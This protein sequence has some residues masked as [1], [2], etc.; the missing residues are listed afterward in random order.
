MK[1]DHKIDSICNFMVNFPV[2]S[3]STAFLSSPIEV[4]SKERDARHVLMNW[5]FC[6][7]PLRIHVPCYVM[8]P[9]G[10][11]VPGLGDEKCIK[12]RVTARGEL[13]SEDVSAYQAGSVQQKN[14]IENVRSARFFKFGT[15]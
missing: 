11:S 10:L 13:G 6:G 8:V 7:L 2:T 12:D 3:S 14:V 9:S 15:N 5:L 4:H 1:E